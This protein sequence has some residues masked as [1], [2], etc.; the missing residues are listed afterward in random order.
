MNQSIG[1]NSTQTVVWNTDLVGTAVENPLIVATYTLIIYD[2]ASSVSATAQ[3]GYLQVFDQ[4]TF[5]MYTP[6][7]YADLDGW[8]CATCNSAL[9][10]NERRVLGLAVGMA[11]LTVLSF[12]WFINGLGVVL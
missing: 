2:A 4:Y 9:G 5:G 12:T 11:V 3:P 6:Q 1:A 7:P 10:P 8:I